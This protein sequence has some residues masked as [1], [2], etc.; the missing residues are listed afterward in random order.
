MQATWSGTATDE[1]SGFAV[2]GTH[3]SNSPVYS[4]HTP[5]PDEL[6][7]TLDDTSQIALRKTIWLALFLRPSL[8]TS[9]QPTPHDGNRLENRS[10]C[11]STLPVNSAPLSRPGP[12]VV[13]RFACGSWKTYMPPIRMIRLIMRALLRS[14]AVPCSLLALSALTTNLF[15]QQPAGKSTLRSAQTPPAASK[16]GTTPGTST[17]PG[18]VSQMAGQGSVGPKP[19]RGGEPPVMV[20]KPV[21]PEMKEI[22]DEWE[23]KS[24][25]IK[26][27]HGKHTR[28]VYNHVFE[29]EKRAEGKFYV[30]TPDKGRIDLVG[31]P[32]EKKD[33]SKKR[34]PTGKP[35]R[36]EA[37]RDEM[38][39][40]NG[41]EIV[42]VNGD[43][44]TYEVAPLPKELRGTNIIDGPLPFLFGMKATDAEKRYQLSLVGQSEKS[45]TILIIPRRQSDVDNYK[46]AEIRLDKK[47]YL[48]LA[49]KM[50]DGSGL[51]TVYVFEI[52]DVN[53]TSLRSKLAGIFGDSDPFHPDLRKKGYKLVLPSIE[54]G[55]ARP[56]ALGAKG[57]N[58][59][60]A[61]RTNATGFPATGGQQP[62]RQANT[63]PPPRVK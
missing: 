23:Q 15:A 58:G 48:P 6:S 60:A 2:E 5:E 39:I 7:T 31:L 53:N 13:V 12:S 16:T 38:W 44:K 37:D 40:C 57:A 45:L 43:E 21:S 11:V 9:D 14:Y 59:T 8:S 41:E 47:T 51:E 19:V 24:A 52:L 54:E 17:K 32:P 10:G 18:Q 63:N 61:P 33:V 28:Y 1:P 22:L 26:S 46:E 36:I 50:I 42:M 56:P 25:R 62:Q 20:I 55:T 49:V 29:L 34:G 35:F 3:S 4:S 30:E 27:L